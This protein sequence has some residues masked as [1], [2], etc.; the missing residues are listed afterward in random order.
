[1]RST[2]RFLLSLGLII[3]LLG[4][5]S[6]GGGD[7]AS[8]SA[9]ATTPDATVFA[10]VATVPG[11]DAPPIAPDSDIAVTFSRPVKPETVLEHFFVL[12]EMTRESVS[13]TVT[14]D[15]ATKTARFKPELPFTMSGHYL[16]RLHTAVTDVTGN[17]LP[18]RFEWSFLVED[19]PLT[20]DVHF[21]PYDGQT[22]VHPR[23]SVRMDFPRKLNAATVTQESFQLLANGA[24]VPATV[25]YADEGFSI[26]ASLTPTGQMALGTEYNVRL[27]GTVTTVTGQPLGSELA[28]RF[29]TTAAPRAS[30]QFGDK[31]ENEAQAITVDPAGNLIITGTDLS[32]SMPPPPP[33]G[34]PNPAPTP[35][36]PFTRAWIR[37]VDT[38]GATIWEVAPFPAAEAFFWDVT[39]DSKG[40]L[41]VTGSATSAIASEPLL[42]LSDIIVVKVRGT[43]GTTVWSRQLGTSDEDLARAVTVDS[44]DAVY[45]TGFTSGTLAQNTNAGGVDVVI[46]K[47]NGETG[48]T[49]W[50]KQFGS[51]GMDFGTA[52]KTDTAANVFVT[53]HSSDALDG[54]SNKGLDD[55]FLARIAAATGEKT[56]TRMIGTANIEEGH[57]LAVS[58]NGVFVAGFTVNPET[59][60]ADTMVAAFDAAGD[61]AVWTKTFD[62]KGMSMAHN[63]TVDAGGMLYVTGTIDAVFQPSPGANLMG[64]FV[65]QVTAAAGELKWQTVIE[66]QNE[67]GADHEFFAHVTA[68]DIVVDTN[69]NLR[70]CGS[71]HGNGGIDGFVSLG[72]SDAFLVTIKTDGQRL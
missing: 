1:M 59:G 63:L 34:G 33:G 46:A 42:G 26:S 65:A 37:K 53:G 68:N 45:L 66:G 57:G 64:G 9:P 32:F 39:A 23:A 29:T 47:L 71:V 18:V 12:D 61:K 58:A 62:L 10:V 2:S 48:A 4:I 6:C 21:A 28:W 11:E 38:T 14:Y 3:A 36:T 30:L 19:P 54:Q 17:R 67:R 7:N 20:Q 69:N 25:A 49:T 40:D 15:E 27:A 22:E 44:T 35:A 43:D 70:V 41:L 8:P 72:A 13:G 50:L 16:G 56:S 60:Q 55:I 24:P 52:I 5:A 31:G 51:A